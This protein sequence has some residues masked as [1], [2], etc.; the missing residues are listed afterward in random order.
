MA[1]GDQLVTLVPIRDMNRAIKFYTKILGGRLGERPPGEMKNFWASLKLGKSVIWL[2]APEK[3]EKRTLA[4]STFLVKNIR[5]TVKQL[6]KKG[7]KFQR[8]VRA[9]PDS[10]VKGP[11]AFESFGASAFFKDT[12]GNLFMIW[13]NLGPM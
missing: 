1:F 3:R 11:I 10:R 12:E 7:V 9:S 6:Q 8:A 2:I 13:Q 5:S 4:Y